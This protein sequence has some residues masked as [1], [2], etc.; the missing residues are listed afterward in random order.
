MPWDSSAAS[1]ELLAQVDALQVSYIRALDRHDMDAWA[2]CF[3]DECSYV[4]ISRENEEQGLPVAIMM[5]DSR[6]RIGDRVTYI[7]KIWAGT[8][9]DYA[10]RHFVQRLSCSARPGGVVSVESNF[11][12]AYTT[13]RGRSELLAT[14]IYQDE[15]VIGADGPRFKSKRAVLDTVTTPRY[16]VYPL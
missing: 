11:M 14:G 16:L 5:D 3:A 10:T 7:T 13:A 12:V 4:C 2:A 8:F 15:V 1:P 9:E 6:A